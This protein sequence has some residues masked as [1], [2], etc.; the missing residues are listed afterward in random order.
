M[1]GPS[2]P[3]WKQSDGKFLGAWQAGWLRASLWPQPLAD[4]AEKAVADKV[5][6][7]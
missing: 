3:P 4:A 6:S 1:E 2:A 5:R 7:S